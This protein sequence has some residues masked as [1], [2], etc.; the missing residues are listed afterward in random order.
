MSRLV[1][2]KYL[3]P[4]SV[5]GKPGVSIH[6]QSCAK[7]LPFDIIFQEWRRSTL[8][9]VTSSA[10]YH[11]PKKSHVCSCLQ[12]L[13][14]R[15]HKQAN[16][17]RKGFVLNPFMPHHVTGSAALHV[18]RSKKGRFSTTA[19]TSFGRQTCWPLLPRQHF[20]SSKSAMS[21]LASHLDKAFIILLSL[22]SDSS[23]PFQAGS[24][25]TF[26]YACKQRSAHLRRCG[27]GS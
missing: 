7:L 14:A 4:W 9:I 19:L 17:S 20:S 23:G 26:A 6:F 27:R 25:Q 10:H 15:Q 5:S 21:V 2:R 24:E 18:C 8:M 22:I 3:A 13:F 12:N 16:K 11:L 1:M